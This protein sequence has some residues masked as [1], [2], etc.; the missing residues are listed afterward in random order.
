V[1]ISVC[2]A[3]YQGERFIVAMLDSILPQLSLLD[4][5]I[6][7]DDCSSDATL[8]LIESYKDPRIKIFRHHANVG[9]SKN[10][11]NALLQASGEVIFVADQDDVWLSNKVE[12]ML[13]SL[14][15]HD[16]VISD[17]AVVDG[18]LRPIAPSHFRQYGVR[19]GFWHNFI[20]TRYIGAAMA[21]RRSVLDV[22]L[23]LPRRSSLCAYDYWIAIVGELF[24]KVDVLETPLMLYRRHGGT[25][26]TGGAGSTFSVWHRICVRAYCL[27]QLAGRA[28]RR[29]SV[30]SYSSS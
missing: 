6:V 3:T 17:V 18:D 2:L 30:G 5:V 22:A 29:W 23:P 13:D 7:S 24:F 25:A 9:Y 28:R 15:T 19:S 20:R 10:F 27:V 4:E 14:R 26:S 1:K 21:M 16:L 8:E 11:E 12:L